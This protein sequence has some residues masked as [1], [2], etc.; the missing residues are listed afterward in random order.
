MYIDTSADLFEAGQ[1]GGAT[2]FVVSGEGREND[3][4]VDGGWRIASVLQNC[5]HL[6]YEI[7]DDVVKDYGRLSNLLVRGETFQ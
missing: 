4:P 2:G 7:K 6:S 1:S 5:G 3:G